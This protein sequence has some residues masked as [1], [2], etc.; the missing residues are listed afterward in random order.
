VIRSKDDV[1]HYFVVNTWKDEPVIYLMRRN[2]DEAVELATIR[3]PEKLKRQYIR[4]NGTHKGVYKLDGVVRDW[5][6][7]ELNEL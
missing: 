2:S 7:S 3:M 5:L 1:S 4:Q 6:K